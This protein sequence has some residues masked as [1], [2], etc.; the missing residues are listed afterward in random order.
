MERNRWYISRRAEEGIP[1]LRTAARQ[2]PE[3]QRTE[4]MTREAFEQQILLHL[5][6]QQRRYPAMEQQ[7]VV[8]FVFQAMLGV[9]HL[10][11]S[12]GVAEEGIA[13]E[14]NLLSAD[15]AEP[16]YEE[17]SP[18]WCRL[19]LRSAKEKGIT[20]SVI[21]GLMFSSGDSMRF[22]RKDVFM[23]CTALAAS[24]CPLITD[25]DALGL[26]MEET[27]LP[28]HSPG[29]REQYHTAYRV[30]SADWIPCM[31][32]IRSI[33]AQQAD[34]VLVTIDGPCASG[35]TTLADRL[36]V[37]FNAAVVHTDDFVIPHAQKTPEKLAVPGGN[38]DAD[39]LLR[40]VVAPWKRGVPVRYRKYDCRNDRLLP[41]EKLPDC[42]TL[43]LE[44]SY[45]NLPVIREYADVRIFVNASRET[46]IRR[47]Q[48]RESEQ[49]MKMFRDRWIPLEDL[50]FRSFMLP[51][52]QCI[53]LDG[54]TEK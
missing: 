46:R 10:L 1:L 17:L 40:E 24:G 9:G 11:S 28:S 48:Q 42:R 26:I 47:L 43:I 18:A 54:N 3:I 15:P 27:W 39:R 49:S 31:E 37:V 21:A 4:R 44:G 29:C 19:S 16:L 14:M 34:R 8:K 52:R 20:P 51:D 50:Y 25:P 13:V 32:T 53:V 7:D 45:C 23:F 35:K 5:Q 6:E 41:E 33:A 2:Q 12:R 30:I 22:T 36:A 38:C